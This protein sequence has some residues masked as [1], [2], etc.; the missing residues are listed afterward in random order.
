MVAHINSIFYNVAHWCTKF[1]S[2]TLLDTYW[3]QEIQIK[4]LFK[5]KGEKEY[6]RPI[7][8]WE[9]YLNVKIGKALGK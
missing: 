4:Y 3:M 5:N 7:E 2:Y 1:E 8:Y 9:K 6:N